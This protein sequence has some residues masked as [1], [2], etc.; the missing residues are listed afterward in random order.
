MLLFN[1]IYGVYS[2]HIDLKMS[3]RLEY[4]CIYRLRCLTKRK[5]SY[6]L[7]LY[8]KFKNPNGEFKPLNIN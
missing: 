8:L 4:I 3:F 7:R 6:T 2:L 1:A 5:I